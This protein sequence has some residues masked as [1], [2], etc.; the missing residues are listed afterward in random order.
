M[1][2]EPISTYRTFQGW[3]CAAVVGGYRRHLHYIGFTKREAIREFRAY[4][5]HLEG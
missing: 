3:E 5:R 1:T 4:L 2:H